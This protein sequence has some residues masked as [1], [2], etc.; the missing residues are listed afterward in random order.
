MKEKY[1]LC[2]LVDFLFYTYEEGVAANRPMPKATS[3]NFSF[4]RFLLLYL[5]FQCTFI[6]T[7]LSSH[8]SSETGVGF[9]RNIQTKEKI[10]FPK[11]N[12]PGKTRN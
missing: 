4:P 6:Y 3:N 8:N 1:F 2:V 5:P 9:F 12:N 7:V 10:P 11:I